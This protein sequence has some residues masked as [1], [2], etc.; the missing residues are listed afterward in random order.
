[1]GVGSEDHQSPKGDGNLICG[2]API[3]GLPTLK[4][5]N[6][7]KGTETYVK[8]ALIDNNC[9]DSEDHQSPKG[10]GNLRP[11]R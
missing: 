11:A 8:C 3:A 6:P 10:D 1:M 5:T 4:T 2:I 9:F 7:R